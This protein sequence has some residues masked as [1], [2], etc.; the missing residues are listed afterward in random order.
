MT[1]RKTST[2]KI[3][4]LA[5]PGVQPLDVSGPLDVFA[6]A[7]QGMAIDTISAIEGR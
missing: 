7:N 1:M 4:I 5:M 3:A 2:K 6:R